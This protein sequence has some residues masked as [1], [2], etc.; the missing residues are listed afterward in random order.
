MDAIQA[1]I[2]KL[3]AERAECLKNIGK[4]KESLAKRIAGTATYTFKPIE[5]VERWVR[6]VEYNNNKIIADINE[7]ITCLNYGRDR[8]KLS[9][10][11]EAI[12]EGY[13]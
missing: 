12:R 5:V 8:F 13:F 11:E 1:H 7:V 2:L 9:P 10:L 4:A 6:E 3:E